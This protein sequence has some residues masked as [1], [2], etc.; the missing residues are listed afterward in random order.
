VGRSG[1]L[2]I[3]IDGF[4]LY[5]LIDTCGPKSTLVTEVFAEMLSIFF[6]MVSLYLGSWEMTKRDGIPA[7]EMLIYGAPTVLA[8]DGMKYTIIG[9][10][11][12]QYDRPS[13]P[14]PFVVT[15]RMYES[16]LLDS[17][18]NM[19]EGEFLQTD[20]FLWCGIV[21]PF[22]PITHRPRGN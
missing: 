6:T 13:S 15:A 4:R 16:I 19:I 2:G 9:Q 18:G 12:Y 22:R 3:D 7:V 8:P 5:R 17:D 11:P 21:V 20:S 1:Q 14:A 10:W